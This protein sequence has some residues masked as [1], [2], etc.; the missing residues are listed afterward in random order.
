MVMIV[1]GPFVCPAVGG[2][3]WAAL[4][5]FSSPSEPSCD[6]CVPTF[7]NAVHNKFD[8]DENADFRVSIPVEETENISDY[9]S[10]I[11]LVTN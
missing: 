4:A 2:P 6:G 10:K 1:K 7:L 8:I 9:H 5:A 11:F 3:C